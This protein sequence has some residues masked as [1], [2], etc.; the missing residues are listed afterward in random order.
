MYYSLHTT[1]N[2]FVLAKAILGGHVAHVYIYIYWNKQY[3]AFGLGVVQQNLISDVLKLINRQI[4][5]RKQG[6]GRGRKRA[7]Y[8]SWFH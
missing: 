3:E 4:G 5:I 2:S 1:K 8:I 7:K 6:K